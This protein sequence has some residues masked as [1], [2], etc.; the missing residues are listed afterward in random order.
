MKWETIIFSNNL[1]YR[2]TRH[3]AFWLFFSLHFIIQNL[4]VGGPGEGKTTRTFFESFVHSLYFLPTYVSST[5]LLTGALLPGYLFKKDYTKFTISVLL[6]LIGSYISIYYSGVLYLHNS[7]GLPYSSI[8]FNEN[9]YHAIVDGIFVSFMLL[10]IS[11]GIKCAKKWF[12]QQRENERLSKQQLAKELQLLKTSL[13]PRFLFHSLQTVQ[14]HIDK[15]SPESPSLILQLSDLLSYILYEKD[16]NWVPLQ[17]ELDILR[18]YTKLEEKRLENNLILN[19]HFPRSSKEKIIAP[20]LLLS[21]VE[22]CFEYFTKTEQKQPMLHLSSVVHEN[23]LDF[24]IILSK[25]STEAPEIEPGEFFTSSRR[26][27]QNQYDNL[28]HWNLIDGKETVS[29]DLKVPLYNITQLENAKNEALNV[30]P[31]LI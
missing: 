3:L 26:Q 31:E 28:H 19:I 7:R 4:M 23:S 10:S 5:Y 27:L 2:L 8:T 30:E 15:C 17:K 6:L 22:S 25:Y 21:V 9:K 18:S 16:E 11:A 24:E 29:I 1:K 13:H 20:F 12:F 14:T